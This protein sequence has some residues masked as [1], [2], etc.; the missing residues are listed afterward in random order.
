MIATVSAPAVYTLDEVASMMKTSTRTIRGWVD[1][2]HFPM[3]LRLP[4]T[5]RFPC[6]DVDTFLATGKLP[7]GDSRHD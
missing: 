3:P 1:A 4:G 7:D 2:R 6:R 5:M